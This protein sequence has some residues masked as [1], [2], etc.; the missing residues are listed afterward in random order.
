MFR[1]SQN[2]RG[3][4]ESTDSGTGT[5]GLPGGFESAAS[6]SPLKAKRQTFP[7][8]QIADYT[9]RA[10]QVS[11]GSQAQNS[12]A[13]NGN[14]N[15][16]GWKPPNTSGGTISHSAVMVDWIN[17]RTGER[18]SATSGSAPPDGEGWIPAPRTGS[19]IVTDPYRTDGGAGGSGVNDGAKPPVGTP[20]PAAIN[21]INRM[22]PG[23][24]PWN[25]QMT[26]RDALSILGSSGYGSF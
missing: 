24:L 20:A 21:N 25:G 23:L 11:Q 16:S 9:K 22:R 18:R 2:V 3:T 7:T 5:G 26:L 17:P 10:S 1:S 19:G 15:N 8:G 4:R 13:P 6:N 12:Q 14:Q